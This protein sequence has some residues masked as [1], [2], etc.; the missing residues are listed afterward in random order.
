[1]QNDVRRLALVAVCEYT[2]AFLLTVL[3]HETAHALMALAVGTHPVLYSSYV[4]NPPVTAERQ[5]LIALAGPGFSLAQGLALLAGARRGRGTGPGALFGLFLGV[6]GLINFLGYVMTGPFVPYGDIGQA[7]KTLNVPVA[8]AIGAAI[9]AAIALTIIVQRTAPLFM[10]FV[11]AA[12]P[13][14]VPAAAKAHKRPYLRAL[15]LWPWLLGSV[16][17]TAVAWPLPTLISLVYPPMSS[18]V[19]G[20]AFGAAVGRP[21]LLGAPAVPGAL[22]AS[23]WGPV[24]MLGAVAAVFRLVSAGVRL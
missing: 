8:A 17:I 23:P 18:M 9:A 6:F 16:L 19:L 24:L 15:L 2:A 3:L 11:P 4:D 22:R 14:A 7:E 21:E 5:V 1:M 10:R 13:E 12:G 20:A